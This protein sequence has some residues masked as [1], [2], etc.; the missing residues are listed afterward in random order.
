MR[1][2]LLLLLLSVPAHAQDVASQCDAVS[3]QALVVARLM[4]S[5]ASFENV[6]QRSSDPEWRFLVAKVYR[7]EKLITMVKD[8]QKEEFA[9][10]FAQG[11][12]IRCHREHYTP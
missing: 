8:E 10:A 7:H 5:G 2:I 12:L 11:E 4:A 6:I 9:K 1:A 3:D